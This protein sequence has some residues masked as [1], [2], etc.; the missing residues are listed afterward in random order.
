[1]RRHE[2][3]GND[4]GRE[5]IPCLHRERVDGRRRGN[6]VLAQPECRVDHVICVVVPHPEPRRFEQVGPHPGEQRGGGGEWREERH[7]VERRPALRSLTAAGVS[8]KFGQ[9]GGD[10]ENDRHHRREPAHAQ[11]SG[12]AREQHSRMDDD[13][14][15]SEGGQ[16]EPARL[17]SGIGCQ[18]EGHRA[19]QGDGV[20][21][22]HD[23][24][25]WHPHRFP[26]LPHTAQCDSTGYWGPHPARCP[27]PNSHR[28]EGRVLVVLAV[29]WSRFQ[30]PCGPMRAHRGECAK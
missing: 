12:Q 14:I 5:R 11:V 25:Y 17:A 19:G 7:G 29:P 30:S 3:G 1:M 15:A 2:P 23:A 26:R 4:A 10:E 28:P 20:Q 6:R 18:R 22:Q 16:T 24:L 13:E 27:V 8:L 21:R 9:P